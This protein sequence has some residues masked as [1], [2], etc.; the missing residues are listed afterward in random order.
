MLRLAGH[1]PDD[2][3]GE[4]ARFQLDSFRRHSE[5][6]M[7]ETLHRIGSSIR[8]SSFLKNQKWLWDRVE[9]CW[10]GIFEWS[11]NRRGYSTYI[12]DDVF[13]LLYVFGSRYDRFDKRVYEPSFYLPFVQRIGEGMTVFDIGAYIGLFTLGAAKRVGKS[14]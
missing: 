4:Y 9:P 7:L 11:S 5:E 2:R 6:F 10:E 12:N 13:K 8:H 14:G 3:N 1:K